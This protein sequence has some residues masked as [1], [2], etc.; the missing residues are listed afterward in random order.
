MPCIICETAPSKPHFWPQFSKLKCCF[1]S[2][3]SQKRVSDP[4]GETLFLNLFAVFRRPLAS[5]GPRADQDLPRR[6]TTRPK[7]SKDVPIPLQDN[8]IPLE[9]SPRP[10]QGGTRPPRDAP[11]LAQDPPSLCQTC[12]ESSPRTLRRCAARTLSRCAPKSLG[13]TR[14]AKTIHLWPPKN[15]NNQNKN[16]TK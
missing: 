4:S 2:S 13:G 9:D 15:A 3:K 11:R 10:P 16:S 7:S 6:P 5:V 1:G 12:P 8:P 14:E